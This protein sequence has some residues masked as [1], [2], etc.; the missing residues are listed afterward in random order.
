MRPQDEAAIFASIEAGVATDM[1]QLTELNAKV[2]DE[3]AKAD[4]A[5]AEF[6]KNDDCVK[7]LGL[8]LSKI[9]IDEDAICDLE[10]REQREED[11]KRLSEGKKFVSPYLTAPPISPSLPVCSSEVQSKTCIGARAHIHC[12]WYSK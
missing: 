3:M 12:T 9:E 6:L 5:L 10:R 1:K 4:R 7:N 8:D 2:K 11:E